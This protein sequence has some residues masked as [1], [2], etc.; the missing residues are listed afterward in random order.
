MQGLVAGIKFGIKSFRFPD[1]S[2]LPRPELF[3]LLPDNKTEVI[4]PR[5]HYII[6]YSKNATFFRSKMLQN[7]TDFLCTCLYFVTIFIFVQYID[8]QRPEIPV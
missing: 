1:G 4:F 5:L 2:V 8:L 7:I 3:S 6:S